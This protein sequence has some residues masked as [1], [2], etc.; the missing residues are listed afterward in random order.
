MLEAGPDYPDP[1][2]TPAMVRYGW[3]GPSIIDEPLDLDWAYLATAS[4]SSGEIACPVAG[5]SVVRAR[6]TAGSS[7]AGCPRTWRP[8]RRSPV[9][10]SN[11]PRWMRPISGL[12]A[13][14]L[15]RVRRWAPEGLG[16][17]PGGVRRGLRGGRLWRD[18][19]SQRTRCDGRGSPAV[20]PGRTGPL[21]PAA[22]LPDA[23]RSGRDRTSRSGRTRRPGGSSSRTARAC[24]V[25]VDGPDGPGRVEA[26][27]VIVA[28]GAIG[29]PHLLLLS[30]I[31]PADALRA[32]GIAPVADLPGV[33][34]NLR[35]HPKNWV[36][37]RLRD[38]VA[39]DSAGRRPPD[40]AA[41]HRDAARQTA[42][43]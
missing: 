18:R 40:I 13:D 4:A 23:G 31:G 8:G 16:S 30:G 12:E 43:T 27:E 35:D 29:S 37:W 9:P 22:G 42:A 34:R 6:S 14:R 20:Q 11:G 38:D 7:C 33:G 24:A 3:G 21:E 5:S 15:F 2:S 26:G 41:L 32:L 25:L 36:E 28:A 39:M 19:R 1:E 10:A 17:D